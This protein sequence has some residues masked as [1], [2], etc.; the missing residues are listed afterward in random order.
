MMI[1]TYSL[2]K[3]ILM[4]YIASVS[5][6]LLIWLLLQFSFV[7]SEIIITVTDVKSMVYSFRSTRETLDTVLFTVTLIHESS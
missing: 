4:E 3:N 7:R 2:D 6:S 1:Y 5:R